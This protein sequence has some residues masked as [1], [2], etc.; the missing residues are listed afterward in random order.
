[1][2]TRNNEFLTGDGFITRMSLKTQFKIK[3]LVISIS[4]RKVHKS[5]TFLIWFYEDY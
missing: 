2:K 1:M 5:I 3:F 4:L